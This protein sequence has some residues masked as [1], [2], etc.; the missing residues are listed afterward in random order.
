MD[1][2][3][4]YLPADINLSNPSHVGLIAL[5][6][7]GLFYVTG[8]L[9]SLLRMFMSAFILPGKSLKSMAPTGSWALVTGASDGIG[10]EF[11]KQ[12]AAKGYNVLLVSRTASKLDD[13]AAS[14]KSAYPNISTAV[15]AMD[16][17]ADR[18]ADYAALKRLIDERD[19]GILVNNVGLSHD[20]PAKFVDTPEHEMR[21]IITVNCMATLR[22]TALV[23]PGMA[24]RRRG[25]ILTMGSFAGSVTPVPLLATYSGSKAFL[26]S[27]S[28]ALSAELA[29]SNVHVQ[30]VESYLVVSSMSKVRR[31]SVAIPTP[32]QL[33]RSTL[34]HVGRSGG[35]G[36]F[37]GGAVGT[38]Y[39]AHAVGEWAIRNITGVDRP[40]FLRWNMGV[41]ENIRKSALRK[42]ER[43]RKGQ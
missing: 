14:I 12:L 36:S 18:D 15:F 1:V 26:T 40:W 9:R 19:V 41:H 31:A 2:I 28:V 29:P 3:L 4:K 39:W 13:V 27:W 20:I 16:F 42:A 11:S 6:G 34:S 43:Q 8:P 30:L 7:L 33:V 32:K 37:G 23:A 38:P 5:A 10:A 22:V 24:Q 21:G 35:A 17:A 25:L